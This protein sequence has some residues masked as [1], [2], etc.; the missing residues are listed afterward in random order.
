[1]GASMAMESVNKLKELLCGDPEAGD[2]R[3]RTGFLKH[4]GF[5]VEQFARQIGVTRTSVYFYIEGRSR[6]K[7]STLI[8]ICDIVGITLAEGKQICMPRSSGGQ[9][10]AM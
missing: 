4:S 3:L 2:Q 5:S 10:K 8:K 6:P 1:M 9:P 7:L